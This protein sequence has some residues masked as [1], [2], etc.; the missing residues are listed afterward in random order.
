VFAGLAWMPDG[1]GLIV[2]YVDPSTGANRGQIGYA[3]YPGG[4]IRAV[5]KDTNSYITPGISAD[6][7]MLAAVQQKRLFTV[8]TVS[9][10]GKEY[11]AP[12]PAIAQQQ[13]DTFSFTWA[14]NDGFFLSQDNRL[15]RGSLDGNNETNLLSDATTLYLAA[16]PDGKTLLLSST[17]N[18]SGGAISIWRINTDGTNLT[19]LTSGG[20][21]VTPACSPD[22]RRVYY[23]DNVTQRVMSVP[24]D[25]GSPEN[26]PGTVIPHGFVSQAFYLDRSPDGRELVLLY[27][28]GETNTVHKLVLITLNAG[29]QPPVRFLDPNP[30]IADAARFTPDGKALVYP[31]TVA[32]ADNVWLQPLDGS[33]GRQI[34]NFKSDQIVGLEW[35][36]DGKK[37]AVMQRRLEAD[38]VLLR[39]TR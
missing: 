12:S 8:S 14:G 2:Q 22:S 19:R 4:Q 15:V 33:P 18:E 29:A 31:I 26:V 27:A 21:D 25:G 23:F 10:N 20:R 28:V 36:P 16:C 3:A 7:S 30:A 6:G 11:S 39:E 32:G 24:T 17:G 38:V 35:S 34:T 9:A 13:R 5:T 37:L 1:R